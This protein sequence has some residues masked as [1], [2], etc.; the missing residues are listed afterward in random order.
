M[1]SGGKGEARL[2]RA[3]CNNARQLRS[4]RKRRRGPRAH[5]TLAGRLRDHGNATFGLAR[6]PGVEPERASGHSAGEPKVSL[7][8]LSSGRRRAEGFSGSSTMAV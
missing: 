4:W 2:K 3:F 7:R 6:S 5:H 8:H 1:T